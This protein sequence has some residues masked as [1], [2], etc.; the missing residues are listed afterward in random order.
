[1]T[2]GPQSFSAGAG[3]DGRIG[4]TLAERYRVDA[5]LDTGA[6]GRVYVGEHVLM[7]KRVAIKVLHPELGAVP[8]FVARFEREAMAAANIDNE[9]VVSATD[10]GKLADGSVFLVLEFVEGKNLRDE[11]AAGPMPLVRGLHIARQIAYALRSAHAQ[12]IVHRDLKPENVMLVNKAGDPDF[13]KVLDFGIAKV[14]IAE[15]ERDQAPSSKPITRAGMVFGT[16]EYM[17]PE[18]ALGQNVDARADLYS[19]GVIVYEMLAGIRPFAAKSDVAILGQQLSGP[20][21]PI[22]QRAPGVTVPP[23]V[24]KF[25]MRLL[26]RDPSARY[27][28]AD[29]VIDAIDQHLGYAPGRTRIPTLR[30]GSL[31]APTT[32]SSI[33]PR[34]SF[35]DGIANP[36]PAAGLAVAGTQGPLERL[37]S[38]I[39]ARRPRLPGPLRKLPAPVLLSLPLGVLGV[40]LG[41]LLVLLVWPAN[42]KGK[43]GAPAASASTEQAAAA[44]SASPAT[45]GAGEAAASPAP[46]ASSASPESSDKASAT[47]LEAA[48]GEGQAAL[49]ALARKYPNDPAVR[50]AL[51]GALIKE[52]DLP[53]AVNAIAHALELDPALANDGQIASALWIA[54]QN[55]KSSEA[56]F[57]LLEGPMGERGKQILKDLSTTPAVRKSVRDEARRA[58][59][60]LRR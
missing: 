21:P 47:E 36:T 14:P 6:M 22:S 35:A 30:Q 49:D 2:A 38:F 25:V 51:S 29:R 9:H 33:P 56:A 5:L 24:E 48:T 55:K 34:P 60:R 52:R 40:S 37:T 23:A 28:T 20:A 45:S 59:G 10:F 31:V 1:M 53:G 57:R 41:F 13:V 32:A 18:Q 44:A 11:I 3:Q 58:L 42:G 12:G 46:P 54:A 8:E 4:S 39:D 19:L 17:P 26:E 7:R 16:P 50:V 43:P 15:P 27:Q